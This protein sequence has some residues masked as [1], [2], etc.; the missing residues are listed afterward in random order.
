MN[1]NIR[2][3]SASTST[4]IR[5]NE[6]RIT[7]SITTMK[8]KIMGKRGDLLLQKGM[9]EYG[10]AEAGAKCDGPKRSKKKMLESGLK[11]VKMLKD[12]LKNLA[13]TC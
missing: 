13:P 7:S 10:C 1:H 8:R 2:R 11:A 6:D 4:S 3:E 12:M 5:K 9:I